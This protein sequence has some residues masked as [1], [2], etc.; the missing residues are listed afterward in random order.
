MRAALH[1][2][3]AWRQMIRKGVEHQIA[4][5][6][7]G[8]VQRTRRAPPV[9][10]DSFRLE[11]RTGRNQNA[12][13]L[14]GAHGGEAAERRI[15]GLHGLEI[16]LAHDRNCGEIGAALDRV[17]IDALQLRAQRRRTRAGNLENGAEITKEGRFARL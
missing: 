1:D 13:E 14:H 8:G 3:S 16:A 10:A 6:Q 4:L 5:A 15:V 7:T 11:D 17:D 9:L 12:F 2:V